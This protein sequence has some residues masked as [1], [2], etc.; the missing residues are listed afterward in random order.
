MPVSTDQ[1]PPQLIITR[2]HIST[3]HQRTTLHRAFEQHSPLVT[4]RTY[5]AITQPPDALPQRLLYFRIRSLSPRS[6]SIHLRRSAA[7]ATMSGQQ[8]QLYSTPEE[9]KEIVSEI[10]RGV[11]TEQEVAAMQP[12]IGL[13]NVITSGTGAIP[14]S[15]RHL[16]VT[17]NKEYVETNLKISKGLATTSANMSNFVIL[18]YD[19]V[20]NNVRPS[21]EDIEEMKE[22]TINQRASWIQEMDTFVNNST[23]SLIKIQS[24]LIK[25]AAGATLGNILED[26]DKF[27]RELLA[28]LGQQYDHRL[29]VGRN[30]GVRNQLAFELD[31]HTQCMNDAAAAKVKLQ[32]EIGH[33]KSQIT[34]YEGRVQAHRDEHREERGSFW[35]FSWKVRDVHQDN[36]ERIAKADLD[37]LMGRITQLEAQTTQISSA[38]SAA[39]VTEVK[40]LQ[41][42][43]VGEKDALEKSGKE[44]EDRV[45]AKHLE[46]DEA[47]KEIERIY[48]AAGTRDPRAIQQITTIAHGVSVA[49]EA[50]TAAYGQLGTNL[51]AI[52]VSPRLLLNSVLAAIKLIHFGDEIN[53]TDL[54]L[55][56]GYSCGVRRIN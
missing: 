27:E 48:Q 1:H 53:K 41:G 26:R 43:A 2:L 6:L 24:E 22:L 12:W 10:Q 56:T 35:I 51:L 45:K 32:N 20:S 37:R 15:E 50:L 55:R 54:L 23:Q 31:Y 29:A 52:R 5:P 13:R 16:L 49:Q 18:A 4:S 44:L 33:L 25:K 14:E 11:Q 34:E 42:D 46:F 8:L 7:I 36:G 19:A 30:E 21:A 3:Q 38:Q 40:R 9:Q 47:I 28:L 39:R 17:L